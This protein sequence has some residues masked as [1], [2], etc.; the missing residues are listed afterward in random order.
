MDSNEDMA[1]EIIRLRQEGLGIKHIA[2]AVAKRTDF[3]VRTL[4]EHGAE[5][6]P[7]FLTDDEKATV[8]RLRLE[9][10]SAE[11]I[12]DSL[13]RSKFAVIEYLTKIKLN[14]RIIRPITVSGNV[15]TIKLTRDREALVDAS[16]LDMV[17]GRSW[18]TT[19]IKTH[20]YAASRFDGQICYLHRY[21]MGATD[22]KTIVDHINGDTLDNRRGNLRLATVRENAANSRRRENA[23]GAIG[24]VITTS[25][26]FYAAVQIGLGTFDT[27]EEAARAYD[28]KATEIFGDFAMTNEKKG[29]FDKKP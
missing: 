27:L 29:F 11:V 5:G 19:G 22:S 14:D 10:H 25:G 7:Y 6:K 2:R 3:V 16:D 24:V 15:A 4:K 12:S 17:K 26:K 18:F 13:G 28:R 9:G 21:L 20:P 1:A 23:S 8:K